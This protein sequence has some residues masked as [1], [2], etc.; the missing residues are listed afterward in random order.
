MRILLIISLI[1][2]VIPSLFAAE[3][4][5]PLDHLSLSQLKV[6]RDEVEEE[7]G[8]LATYSMRTG[9]G[10]AGHRSMHHPDPD[11]TEWIKVTLESE[12]LIDQIILTPIILRDTKLGLH[13]DGFPVD[14]KILAGT[15]DHP[16]GVEI[17]S[18]T[19]KDH[20]LPRIAP[21]IIDFEAIKASWIKLEATKLS[22]RDWDEQY[23]L[24]LSEIM[25]FSGPE[26]VAIHGLVEVSSSTSAANPARLKETLVDGQ[27]P[28]LMDA[29]CGDKSIAF[30]STLDD[31][32]APA[33]T[34]DLQQ[35]EVINRLH[36]HTV[37]L[38]DSIP[39]STKPALG[40]PRHMQ[41]TGAN[42]ADF[43]DEVL[44]MEYQRQDIFNAGPIIIGRFPETPCR[45]VRLKV[46]ESNQIESNPTFG[47]AE[48]ELF[49]KGRNVAL[50]KSVSL[51]YPVHNLNRSLDAITD[52]RNLYGNILPIR[53]WMK[54]LA[55]R[56][57][58]EIQLPKIRE[59]IEKRYIAQKQ[60]LQW[61]SWLA[62]L[63][64]GGIAFTILI[65][66]NLQMRQVAR[67]KT[68]FAAD[69]HD[70]LGA[71]LHAIGLLGDI[72]KESVH[73]PDIL[74]KA[75]DKIRALTERSGEA[76]R[77]CAEM[78][79]S[80]IFGK[81][82]D[83]MQRTANRI[84]TDID[85]NL[86]IEGEEILEKLPPRT[87][88]DLFLFYKESLVN[89]S[90]HSRAEKVDVHLKANH[91]ITLLISDNGQGLAGE[92]PSSLKRRARLLG[93]QVSSETSE[94]GGASI[95]LTFR[96]GKFNFRRNNKR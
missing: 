22:A 9:I 42:Q 39:Q 16:E 85:F 37:E 30:M 71:N 76:A 10:T 49:S 68:R 88:A 41:V 29:A 78:Q 86:S 12:T 1:A 64:A 58:L 91:H 89:I 63:L 83:D 21:F 87:K 92:V 11:H 65:T 73:S 61:V 5:Q 53:I 17:A 45:Y 82:P 44:L 2:A 40:V 79:K 62:A 47:C 48:L 4:F 15:A 43:S 3:N 56:H 51:N 7:L 18:F 46:I 19:E 74:V 81:L 95:T 25:V 34:I 14:F 31:V 67:L 52:G 54:E 57:E 96:P 8:Q 35:T 28:Y 70:E 36:L 38:S 75:V 33:L 6:L 32:D 55:R 69:I 20:L 50:G 72:A 90:R 84:M 27:V 93:G 13:G 60:S 94:T 23:I 59:E 26:N 77:Y 66:H 80:E 24:Q